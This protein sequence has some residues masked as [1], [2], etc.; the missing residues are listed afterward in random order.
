LKLQTDSIAAAVYGMQD[1]REKLA[2]LVKPNSKEIKEDD[3]SNLT[4]VEK[5][6][7]ENARLMKML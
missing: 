7:R 4:E 5:L 1:G 3:E 2:G 6:R